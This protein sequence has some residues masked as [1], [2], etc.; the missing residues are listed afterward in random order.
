MP[1]RHPCTRPSLVFANQQGEI[2]DYGGLHMA[3]AA[4]GVFYQP[5][6][7]DLIELPAGSEI[8]TLPQRLPVGVEAESGDFAVLAEN[9]YQPGE[10][11]QAVAAFMAP[12]AVAPVVWPSRSTLPIISSGFIIPSSL[13]S[14][15]H[16]L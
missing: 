1:A 2:L 3:G 14:V 9:P 11:V 13:L 5:D 10:A 16:K 7:R 8:F 6:S 4:A 15:I 12:A